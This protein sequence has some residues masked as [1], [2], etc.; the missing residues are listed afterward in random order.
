MLTKVDIEKYF[1]AEKQ[2]GLVIFIV[3]IIA[4]ILAVVCYFVLRAPFYKGA[5]IPLVLIGAIQCFIGFSHY[6]SSDK[7]RVRNVY[8]FDMNPQ[9]LK[10]KELPRVAK[11]LT[12]IATFKWGAVFLL[13]AGI[14]LFLLYRSRA[15]QSIWPGLGVAL[16]L[17]AVFM[18]GAEFVAEKQTK[19]YHEQ[20]K[21]FTY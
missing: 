6:T 20:L 17:Q 15:D 9:E 7:S 14:T 3:G 19:G 13:L 21:E 2:V 11:A 12:G 18:F 8:A 4:L 5:A 16:A 1:L 10:D